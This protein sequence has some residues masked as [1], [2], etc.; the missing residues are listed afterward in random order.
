MR[1]SDSR[2]ARCNTTRA[3]AAPR[4][5]HAR[6]TTAAP[7]LRALAIARYF[8]RAIYARANQRAAHRFER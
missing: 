4:I 5:D 6:E 1:A 7:L 3:C 2:A 8:S